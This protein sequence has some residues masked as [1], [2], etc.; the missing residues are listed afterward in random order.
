MLKTFP[1]KIME[2][3]TL[4]WRVTLNRNVDVRSERQSYIGEDIAKIGCDTEGTS[5]RGGLRMRA[6]HIA[7]ACER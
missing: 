1:C 4:G 7:S 5:C 6:S 3:G 2:F